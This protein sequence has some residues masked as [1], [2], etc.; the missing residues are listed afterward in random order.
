MKYLCWENAVKYSHRLFV[1][2]IF[3]GC[4]IAQAPLVEAQTCEASTVASKPTSQYSITNGTVVDLRTG[5]M[6]DQCPWGQS[7][8]TCAVVAGQVAFFWPLAL[9]VAATANASNHKG[10]SDWRLPNV[11]E[12]RSIVEVCRRAPSINDVVFPNTPGSDFL[13]GY[14]WSSSPSASNTDGAWIV[15]YYYGAAW[16]FETRG[17]QFHVRLVRTAR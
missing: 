7:G 11:K 9:G 1:P 10:Y 3:F 6:W 4:V 12:L 8:A 14:F 15:N 13:S 16:D 17:S 5:L 2:L